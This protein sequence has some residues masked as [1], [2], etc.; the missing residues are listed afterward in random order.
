V[1]KTCSLIQGKVGGIQ[2]L[3]GL[4]PSSQTV[5]CNKRTLRSHQVAPAPTE[6]EIGG[7]AWKYDLP[8]PDF[9]QAALTN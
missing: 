5:G 7:A 9:E 4:A 6:A 3:V 8:G 2:V 1:C